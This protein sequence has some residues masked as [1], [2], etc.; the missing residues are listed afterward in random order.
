MNLLAAI[1]GRE[2]SVSVRKIMQKLGS[3]ALWSNFSLKGRKGKRALCQLRLFRVI[4]SKCIVVDD[5]ALFWWRRNQNSIWS[6]HQLLMLNSLTSVF[7]MFTRATRFPELSVASSCENELI[8]LLF[9]AVVF[10]SWL[11]FLI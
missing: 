6:V 8:L 1:G 11:P 9:G 2:L 4:I 5:V 10:F 3:N 7:S